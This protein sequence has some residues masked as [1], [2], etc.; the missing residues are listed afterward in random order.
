MTNVAPPLPPGVLR[1]RITVGD[2][3]ISVLRGG[4]GPPLL[5]LHGA[6][7]S[8]LWL[9]FHD[10]LAE[11]FTVIAPDHPGFGSSDEFADLADVQ[12]LAFHYVDVLA[13]LGHEQ[14]TVVGLSFGGW[15]A[16]ELAAYRPS[17]VER[18]VLINPIGLYIDGAS[19]TDPFALDPFETVGVLFH[20]PSIA[21]GLFPAEPDLDFILAAAKDEA[22]F[23]RFAWS[24]FLHD[25][26]LPRLLPR[27][28]A[29]TLVVA[30]DDDR[31][32]PRAHAER[33]VE[34]L[35]DARLENL[36]SAGHAAPFERPDELAALITSFD[37]R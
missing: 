10:R 23:A 37:G 7:A 28:T 29:P 9:P 32:V 21:A 22:A 8:G 16:A 5:F 30:S 3:A 24:P 25:P 1:E 11:Q 4:D 34:L 27:V 19:I 17:L 2:E 14:V 20:D 18:L 36:A 15:V 12:D 13:A 31:L 6:G 35:P 26:R 33:Y